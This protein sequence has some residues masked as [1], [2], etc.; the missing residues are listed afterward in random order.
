VRNRPTRS[1]SIYG[2]IKGGHKIESEKGG[3]KHASNNGDS[4]WTTTFGPRAEAEC[5]GKNPDDG[6]EG[7]HEDGAKP[8]ATGFEHG[9]EGGDTEG[10]L[11]IGKLHEKNGIFGDET[12][13]KDQADQAVEI[14]IHGWNFWKHSEK[15]GKWFR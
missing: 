8:K 10:S 14:K 15:Q 6:G 5:D 13:K 1:E 11:L 2:D 3:G 4:E 7:G 12:Q 9:L